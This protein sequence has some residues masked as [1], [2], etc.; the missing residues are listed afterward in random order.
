MLT[1]RRIHQLLLAAILILGFALRLL[2]PTLVEFKRDEATIASLF[3][4]PLP[5]WSAG[6]LRFCISLWYLTE[7]L[8][9]NI[10]GISG[11]CGR[12]NLQL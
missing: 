6:T 5:Y 9:A 10:A 12:K 4:P 11:P 1:Q 3:K 7:K 8:I 2:Q